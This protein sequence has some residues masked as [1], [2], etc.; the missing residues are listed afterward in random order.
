[1]LGSDRVKPLTLPSRPWPGRAPPSLKE[2]G[3][4]RGERRPR[5]VGAGE[6]AASFRLGGVILLPLREKVA[7]PG[8]AKRAPEDRLR[9]G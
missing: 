2:R 6:P 9:A 8:R 1:M 7:P 3:I 4:I 5:E